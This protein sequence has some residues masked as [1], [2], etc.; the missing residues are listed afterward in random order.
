MAS[1]HVERGRERAYRK[2]RCAGHGGFSFQGV[3]SMRQFL[4]IKAL[5]FMQWLQKQNRKE[6][7]AMQCARGKV[8]SRYPSNEVNGI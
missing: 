8:V 6:W 4:A 1:A 2:T 3:T 5:T 7:F